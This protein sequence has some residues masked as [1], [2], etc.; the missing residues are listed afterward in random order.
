MRAVFAVMVMSPFVLTLNMAHADSPRTATS[1]CFDKSAEKYHLDPDLLRLIAMQESGQRLAA[2][3]KN[4]NGTVD[5]CAM[6]INS[7]WLPRLARYGI[8]A[9]KLL[10]NGCLCIDTGAWILA[11]E[12][13]K[14]GYTWEAVGAYHS[15][16]PSLSINYA[17]QVLTRRYV[18]SG[19][20]K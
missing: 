2:I 17:R 13:K 5:Y 3:H 19:L 12:V 20:V 9:K 10:T 14:Y 11:R 18:Y 16:N 7:I 1:N 8:T 15:Q 4:R 6:Q